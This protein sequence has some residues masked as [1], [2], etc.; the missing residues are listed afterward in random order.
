MINSLTTS[1]RH[2]QTL[3][4]L[5]KS[6]GLELS[7]LLRRRDMFH[8]DLLTCYPMFYGTFKNCFYNYLVTK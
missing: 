6:R 7:L 5:T 4:N 8:P 1:H 3:F 2:G